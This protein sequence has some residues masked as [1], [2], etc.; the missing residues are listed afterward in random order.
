M[1]IKLNVGFI[2]EHLAFASIDIAFNLATKE[3]ALDPHPSHT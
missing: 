1:D 2:W 3:I